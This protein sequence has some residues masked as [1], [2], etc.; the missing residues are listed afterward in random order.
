MCY[1][2]FSQ[3]IDGIEQLRVSGHY[4]GNFSLVN[5]YY[6]IDMDSGE[7]KVKLTNFRKKGVFSFLPISYLFWIQV[8]RTA[9]HIFWFCISPS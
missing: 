7:L 6:I 4:H 2:D 5:T 3:I 1:Y 8:T 9:V